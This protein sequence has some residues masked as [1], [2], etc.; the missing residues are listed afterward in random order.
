[1]VPAV[2]EGRNRVPVTLHRLVERRLPVRV[3]HAADD[4]FGEVKAEPPTVLVHGPQEVLERA[5]AIATQPLAPPAGDSLATGTE[6]QQVVHLV[7]QIEGRPVR[8]RPG[9]VKARYTVRPRQK[10]YELA[11]VPVRFLCPANFPLRP[12]FVAERAGRAAVRV[13]GPAADAPPPVI[14]FIDLT[15]AKFEPGLYADEPLRFQLPREYQ[16]VQDPPK[17]AAFE[18]VPGDQ[19]AKVRETARTP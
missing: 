1:V 4:R 11:D 16:L 7:Q 9:V 19:P 13:Q 18:L 6:A 3:D 12:Q 10:V 8:T 14:A 15:G 17:S 5:I 2:V